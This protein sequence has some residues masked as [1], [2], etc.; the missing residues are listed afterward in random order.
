MSPQIYYF[1]SQIFIGFLHILIL[2]EI[3]YCTSTRLLYPLLP[4]TKFGARVGGENPAKSK[5]FRRAG[6]GL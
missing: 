5:A 4:K 1:F 2:Y 6:E 3:E